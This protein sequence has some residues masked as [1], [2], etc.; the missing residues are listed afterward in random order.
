MISLKIIEDVTIIALFIF[1]LIGILIYKNFLF[2]KNIYKDKERKE[3]DTNETIK[4]STEI[5]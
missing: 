2:H 1:L 4:Q 3:V 5:K